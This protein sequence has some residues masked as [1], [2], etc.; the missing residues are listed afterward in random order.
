MPTIHAQEKEGKSLCGKKTG[1]AMSVSN[2]HK[3]IKED[4]L[5]IILGGCN[6]CMEIVKKRN[7]SKTKLS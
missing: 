2:F 7:E 3:A 5:A 4:D 6:R 1:L